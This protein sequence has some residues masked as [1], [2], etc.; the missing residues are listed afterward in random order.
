MQQ[1]LLPSKW[2]IYWIFLPIATFV[3][4]ISTGLIGIGLFFPLLLPAAQWYAL[5]QHPANRYPAYWFVLF[6]LY[7]LSVYAVRQLNLPPLR[8]DIHVG[9]IIA[10]YLSQCLA[11]PVL[12]KM[13]NKWQFGWFTV[14]NG[15]A[16]FV[17]YQLF[18]AEHDPILVYSET[19]APRSKWLSGDRWHYVTIPA[20]A[21]VTNLLTGLGLSK[22]TQAN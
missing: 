20:V 15:M 19:L 11:E 16:C 1:R 12:Y 8:N 10:F 7:V 13:V 9:L 4:S 2:L 18:L 22:A 5:K 14:A 17:W 21:T 6:F 3:V